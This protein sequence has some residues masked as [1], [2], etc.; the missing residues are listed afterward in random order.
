[1]HAASHT[2]GDLLASVDLPASSK[3][4][5]ALYPTNGDYYD[6]DLVTKSEWRI[7][8]SVQAPYYSVP[9]EAAQLCVHG[10]ARE[11]RSDLVIERERGCLI[12]IASEWYGYLGARE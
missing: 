3:E 10:S 12:A 5:V 7:I 6:I 11:T 2:V 9:G 8:R 1:L 4:V